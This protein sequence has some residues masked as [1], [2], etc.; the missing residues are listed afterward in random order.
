M[1]SWLTDLG[2]MSIGIV[3]VLLVAIA[4]AFSKFYRK[5]EQGQALIRN[6]F[7]GAKVCFTGTFVY[8]II[9]RAETMDISVKRVV[10]ERAGK[11]GL[12]CRDNLRADIKVAFFVRVND[13]QEDVRHVAK[14]IGVNR[15]SDRTAIIE[16]FDPKFS[17]ALKTVGKKFD[18]VDLYQERAL[19]KDEI[20]QV[21]GT[22]LNGYILDDCAIDYLEQTDIDLLRADNI[23]DAEGIKKIT[24]LTAKQ[25][26]LANQ[27]DRDRERTIKKQDVEAEEAVLELDRQL[28]ESQERQKRE[29]ASIRARENADAMQVQQQ[30]RLKAEGAKIRT[31]EELHVA[32]QNKERQVIVAQK[33]KERTEKIEIERIEKDR[34]LE[35]IE[36]DRIVELTTIEKERAVEV[37][38]KNIQDVIRDRVMVEK[39]VVEEEEKIKD[40]RAFAEAER[41]KTV[42]VTEAGKTAEEA[43]IQEVK[44]AEAKK[45][46]AALEAEQ[47]VIEAEAARKSSDKNAEARKVL[48]EAKAAEDA[49]LGLA[50][51]QV[52]EAKARALEMEGAAQAS[53]IEKRA[54]AEAKG[55]EARATA[56]GKEGAVEAEVIEKKAVSSAKGEEAR[57]E[58]LER[59]GTAEAA[60]MLKKFEADAE[61]IRQKAEA[62][63]LFDEAGRSHEEFK[64]MLQQRLEAILAELDTQKAVAAAQAEVIAKGLENADIELVGGESAFFDKIAGAIAQGRAVDR[65]VFNSSVLTDVKETFFNGDPD[66]FKTQ[67]KGFV[68]QLGI[69]AEDVKNLSIAALI[70]RMMDQSSDEKTRGMLGR[71]LSFARA[72]G[73]D[74]QPAPKLLG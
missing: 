16:L 18:F 38:R 61:G 50:E 67:L 69:S 55:I 46:A 31:E 63:K 13:T 58:A 49:T 36:R 26:I 47:K 11:D 60:N 42:A 5:V 64:L 74:D 6:G 43:M 57:A 40:T 41:A 10:L 44:A 59:V 54:M 4:A 23:L 19:F 71:I 65:M 51:A 48:A 70:N 8:P 3:V 62:M 20:L 30:E 7:G 27:I 72:T 73:L 21:I 28:A 14:T 68:D 66:Y 34:M 33:N 45:E 39:A 25:R 56:K 24:E 29:I 12:I 2:L 9:H 15:A 37:E 32:E 53:V 52:Q 17:E 1:M 35:V 22:D